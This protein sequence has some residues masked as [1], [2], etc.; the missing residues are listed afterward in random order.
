M[1]NYTPFGFSDWQTE[2]AAIKKFGSPARRPRWSRPSTATPTCRSTRSSPTRASR[3]PTFPVIAFSVGEEELAGVD[4]KPLVGHLAA[5]SYFESVDT[6]E[7]KAFIAKVARLHQGPKRVTNDPMESAY[8]LFHM[9]AQAVQQAG[10]TDVDAVRQAMIGQKVKSPSG[11]D[12]GDGSQPPHGEA[13]DDRRN[14]GERP[15]RHRLQEQ[16]A[17]ARGLE[18]LCRSQQ[19]QGRRLVLALGLRRLHRAEMVGNGLEAAFLRGNQHVRLY[20]EHSDRSKIRRRIDRAKSAMQH[21]RWSPSWSSWSRPCSR[22]DR[23]WRHRQ[24]RQYRRRRA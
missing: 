7:N 20:A 8:I 9:W 1:E 21:H 6:P 2:V 13:G 12:R 4:T 24:I 16:G 17:A 19:G 22:P 11:F 10:T 14:P 18:P 5:W 23:P 3:R 15:V